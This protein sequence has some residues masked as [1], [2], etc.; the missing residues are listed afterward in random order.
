MLNWKAKGN[1][2]YEALA[3]RMV[4]GKYFIEWVGRH[5]SADYG[6][7]DCN[8]YCVSHQTKGGGGIGNISRLG[9][10]TLAQAKA[11]AEFD[12]NQQRALIHKYGSYRQV[13]PDEAYDKLNREVLQWEQRQYGDDRHGD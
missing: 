6:A 11:L 2:R 3:S 1:D 13:P 12:H 4:G 9:P 8:F 5:Y 7:Y 10:R